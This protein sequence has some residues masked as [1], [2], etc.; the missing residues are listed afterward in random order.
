L[1]ALIVAGRGS[2]KDARRPKLDSAV[3]ACFF[4]CSLIFPLFLFL[5]FF[6]LFL[7]LLRILP[8]LLRALTLVLIFMKNKT[9]KTIGLA[10]AATASADGEAGGGL[11]R[12]G[13]NFVA[14]GFGG[15]SA[16]AAA[17]ASGGGWPYGGWWVSVNFF[18]CGREREKRERDKGKKTREETKDMIFYSSFH[19][20][21]NRAALP[22]GVVG[23]LTGEVASVASEA[24]LPRPRPLPDVKAGKE[25]EKSVS[26]FF[27]V[28]FSQLRCKDVRCR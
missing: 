15:G 20:L 19:A 11:G 27:S 28:F 23:L 1:Q 6:S 3:I 14:G 18:R 9:K 4:F 17:A 12:R 16:A 5:I 8:K 7:L 25:G 24:D 21:S 2:E 10:L 22:S 13:L 26:C